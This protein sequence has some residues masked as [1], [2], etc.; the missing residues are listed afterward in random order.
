VEA[1][2][3]TCATFPLSVF[4]PGKAP[5]SGATSPQVLG[6]KL[7]TRK[8]A[9][10]IAVNFSISRL[11]RVAHFRLFQNDSLKHQLFD[12]SSVPDDS[13]SSNA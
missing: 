9:S 5:C 3:T 1:T 7:A 6:V 2:G 13:G 11:A 12:V 4:S 10:Q 8:L